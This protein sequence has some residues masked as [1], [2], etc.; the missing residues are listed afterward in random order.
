MLRVHVSVGIYW[1][2]QIGEKTKCFVPMVV[3]KL[4]LVSLAVENSTAKP[5]ILRHKARHRI[6]NCSMH[7]VY[8]ELLSREVEKDVRLRSGS[9][10]N[11]GRGMNLR[12]LSEF[13]VQLNRD[14]SY[15]M[16][17]NSQF[18][19][20]QSRFPAANFIQFLPV[21]CFIGNFQ[22]RFLPSSN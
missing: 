5:I 2:L 10:R 11:E 3:V 17:C 14:L 16:P 20:S 7:L 8:V 4:D 18:P 22:P 21:V 9:M 19:P 6:I 1:N 13:A 12:S 15:L